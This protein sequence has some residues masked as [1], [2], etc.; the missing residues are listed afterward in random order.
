VSMLPG[1]EFL[2]FEELGNGEVRLDD[3][4]LAGAGALAGLVA[5]FGVTRLM[6]G[7]LLR[8]EAGGPGD[9]CR[10]AD[11][12]ARGRGCRDAER[13]AGGHSL[14]PGYRRSAAAD[15]VGSAIR[16]DGWP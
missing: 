9:V 12:A 16:P 5:A 13:S 10:R 8:D 6:Q 15:I 4:V 11:R 7:L 1:S 3:R 14:T 2:L